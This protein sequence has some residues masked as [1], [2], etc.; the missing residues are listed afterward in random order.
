MHARIDALL[1]AAH[2]AGQAPLASDADFLRRAHLALT[3]MIP[4]AAEARAFFV[5]SAPD[6]RARLIEQLLGSREFV[7]WMSVRLD[8]MLME[9]R[10]EK[11]VKAPG[12]QQFLEDSVAANKPWDQLVREILSVDGADEKTR[13]LARWALEREADPHA[14]TRDVGRI[15]L[16][17]DMTCAQCHDHPRIDDY[18]QR[19][20]Y[21]IEAFFSRTYL[22][23]P[24]TNK[25]ALLGEQAQGEATF[26]SVF[27]KIAGTTRPRLPGAEEITEPAVAPAE[28]WTVA[29][30]AK[31]KNVRPIPKFSRRSQLA[32]ALTAH[33]AFRRNL[34][35]RLW[36]LVFGRG[37]V[38]PL[39]LHHSANPPSNPALLDLLAE[40]LGVMKFDA[41]A[42]VRELALTRAFQRALDL[43]EPSPEITRATAERLPVLTQ[44]AKTLAEAAAQSEEAFTK[45]RSSIRET[46]LGAAP[47]ATELKKQETAAV[48]AK[49]LTDAATAEGKK[50]EDALAAKRD[51]LKALA[52]AAGKVKEAAAQTP[53]AAELAQ[54]AKTFQTKADQATGEL[55]PLEKEAVAKKADADAK[56][57]TL[58]TA[59]QA[60]TAARTKLDEAT[61]QIATLQT[62]LDAAAAQKQSDRTKARHAARSTKELGAIVAWAPFAADERAT[63]EAAT[64]SEAALA[65]VNQNIQRLTAELAN[66]PAK[67]ASLE[68]AAKLAAAEVSK[69]T[70][71]VT[72]R[73][74]VATTLME[75]ATKA[76]EAA[77]KL[78]KDAEVQAASAAIK[79]KAD[80]LAVETAALTR[81]AAEAPAKAE[82]AAKVVAETR[83][84]L[85]KAKAELAAA[86]Q[87][88]PAVDTEATAARA[89]LAASAPPVALARDTLLK[90]WTESFASAE[91]APLLPE[92]LCWSVMRATGFLEQQRTQAAA[93]WDQKNKLSDADK[94]NP[95]KQAERTAAIE[96]ALREKLRPHENQYVRSFGGAA[97]QPQT[98]FFATPEQALYFE[99]AGSL[100]SWAH[101]LS[102]RVSALPDPRATAEE[103]YL[104]TLTRL[105]AETEISELSSILAGRPPDKKA[106]ALTDAAWALITSNEFRFRH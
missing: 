66:T 41:K 24:D 46:Q 82:T 30:N 79:A 83:T 56:T 3:G 92:Q 50:A 38:E 63:R 72:Q 43:A 95:Q 102:T 70:E 13:P 7:R 1:D 25:P 11:H 97:G 44:E 54:A 85:E 75:A 37:L 40:V 76:A 61:R 14:L 71:A 32:A 2:P 59:Q 21:G 65:A 98:E 103:L 42:F 15:F 74:P 62:A 90:A 31:D 23:H 45:A 78:P 69:A 100:R 53:E 68:E 12:W 47:V 93:E 60:A 36:Q 80:A 67:L 33:P 16:G 27:T 96:K 52:E 101:L 28:M 84:A 35:N 51:V 5:E 77:A 48:E 89:K 91:L 39:D 9:R 104:S 94:A 6:K 34:A 17:R 88:H 64:R 86:Q 8:L 49:K 57:Q 10:T 87:Q 99:N 4:T 58:T 81:A 73:R 26:T 105:P 106:D 29:P 18:A 19:D 20:Y 22:F 55:P